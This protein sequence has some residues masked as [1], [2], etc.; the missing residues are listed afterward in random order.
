MLIDM[1]FNPRSN[2]S[3]EDSIRIFLIIREIFED[4]VIFYIAAVA[5]F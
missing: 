5:A 1:N 3:I 4:T 2:I